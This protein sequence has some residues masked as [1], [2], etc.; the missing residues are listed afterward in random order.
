MLERPWD[1]AASGS[2]GRGLR[3]ER[4]SSGA[5]LGGVGAVIA[6]QSSSQVTSDESRL[7][8]LRI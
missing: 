1:R 5:V 6:F 4:G 2:G 7:V 3:R 8:F